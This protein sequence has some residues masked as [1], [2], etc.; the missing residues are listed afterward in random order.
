MVQRTHTSGSFPLSNASFS[1]VL[2]DRVM[3]STVAV[4]LLSTTQGQ[5]TQKKIN[6]MN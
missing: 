6:Y 3:L 5:N 2:C 1:V 4:T